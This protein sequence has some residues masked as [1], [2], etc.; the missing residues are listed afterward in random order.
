MSNTETNIINLTA[1]LTRAVDMLLKAHEARTFALKALETPQEQK[2]PLA[3]DTKLWLI[4]KT[5]KE[6]E[7]I[8][9]L[10][11]QTEKY[12][13]PDDCSK[14]EQQVSDEKMEFNE[15]QKKAL[16]VILNNPK[17]C[18]KVANLHGKKIKETPN[19]Q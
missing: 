5:K 11:C 17:V 3:E 1:L 4:G 19:E 7:E 8:E 16:E 10:V 15:E 9:K 2:K 6:L 12:L 18:T 14:N 13:F